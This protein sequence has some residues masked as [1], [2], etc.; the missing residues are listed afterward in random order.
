M[1]IEETKLHFR[2][3]HTLGAAN[4][5]TSFPDA[6]GESTDVWRDETVSVTA[7]ARRLDPSPMKESPQ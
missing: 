3:E 2:I 1:I 5:R 4:V 6:I 7:Q